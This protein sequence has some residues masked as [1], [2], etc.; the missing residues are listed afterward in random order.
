[1]KKFRSFLMASVASIAALSDGAYAATASNAVN[2]P[3]MSR[4]PEARANAAMVNA[5][6][7]KHIPKPAEDT[8]SCGLFETCTNTRV[9]L[10]KG[11]IMIRM[12]G[13]GVF[14]GDR[15]SKASA[16]VTGV[17]GSSSN[18]SH[19]LSTVRAIG[20]G[21]V[22]AGLSK[23]SNIPLR[24][25]Q[26][27]T[28][29]AGPEMTFEYFL[30]DSLSVDLIAASTHHEVDW[31]GAKNG[32]FG[33]SLGHTLNGAVG[34]AKGSNSIPLGTAYVLPPT[35]TI[36][37]HF[38][39]H[40]RFN[41]YAGAGVSAI[42]FH[43]MSTA[44]SGLMMPGHGG[45]NMKG[46]NSGFTGGPSFNL[47]FDYQLVGNWFF[48]MDVKQIFVRM[49]SWENFGTPSGFNKHGLR[50]GALTLNG[51]HIS[52]RVKAHESLDPTVASAG[53]A[54]RF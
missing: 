13:V 18:V 49:H 40:K 14:P 35:L 31:D 5:P 37:Y 38:R 51:A 46:L 41:P 32:L 4:V 11:D 22:G 45:G 1:M 15:D 6:I 12:S 43:N 24:G 34:G 9:G 42:W 8:E 25:H 26:S 30:T 21:S 3:V 50:P 2:A 44:R 17:S 28:D 27:T 48:N 36:A 19:A 54:Y 16:T 20:G 52:G 29:E 47:G 10:G 7:M 23:L 39:P 53:I 33:G